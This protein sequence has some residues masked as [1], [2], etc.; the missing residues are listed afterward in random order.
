MSSKQCNKSQLGGHVGSAVGTTKQ[1]RVCLLC[2]LIL[3][4]SLNDTGFLRPVL[5][6]V[7]SSFF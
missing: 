5:F 7:F 6:P 1:V 3:H 2:A 4:H